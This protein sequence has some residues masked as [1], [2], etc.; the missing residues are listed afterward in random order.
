MLTSQPNR[1]RTVKMVDNWVAS[2]TFCNLRLIRL[3]LAT[4]WNRSSAEALDGSKGLTCFTLRVLEVIPKSAC[5]KAGSMNACG[6]TV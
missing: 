1:V 2:E 3:I 4:L 5:S 6:M